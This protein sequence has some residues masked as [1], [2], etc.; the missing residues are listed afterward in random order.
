[1]REHM[2]VWGYRNRICK[3]QS[4]AMMGIKIMAA[5]ITEKYTLRLA[6]EKTHDDMVLV[7]HFIGFAKGHNCPLIFERRKG[8][9]DLV[10]SLIP[11]LETDLAYTICS[12]KQSVALVI[13]V[14]NDILK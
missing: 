12:P 14:L 7:D 9:V 3:G 6:S 2:I 11:S 10:D 1:M 8:L 5:R 13:Q 4:M